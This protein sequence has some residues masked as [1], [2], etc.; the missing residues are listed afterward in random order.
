MFSDITKTV[1]IL[2]IFTRPGSQIWPVEYISCD[3]YVSVSLLL[4]PL[5]LKQWR[6]KNCARGLYSR[7]ITINPAYGRIRISRPMRILAPIP[8]K[9]LL[10]SKICQK[11]N[12]FVRPF[13]TLY[14][15]EYSNLRPILS[16][17]FL[18]GFRKS[19][20]FGHWT[21]GREGKK[22]FKRS[23]QMTKESV[24]LFLP[25]SKQKCS[26]LRPL[27]SITFLQ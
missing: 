10:L 21:S 22:M 9:I 11:L 18:Q 26:N 6:M 15:Q 1:T 24:K 2:F 27:L 25:I 4:C 23:E 8:T 17:S 16:I 14:E 13:C 3:V 12:F 5:V 20:M 19:T 7:C